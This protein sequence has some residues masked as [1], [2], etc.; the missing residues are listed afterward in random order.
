MPED[1][2]KDVKQRLQ[3]HSCKGVHQIIPQIICFSFHSLDSLFN[4]CK[5]SS[6][7]IA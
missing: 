2:Q 5:Y 3:L 7:F 6:G 4:T 1:E